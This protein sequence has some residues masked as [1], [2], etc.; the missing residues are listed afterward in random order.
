MRDWKEV[1]HF[2]TLIL[3]LLT[4]ARAQFTG[5][6]TTLR[7]L[8]HQSSNFSWERIRS[9]QP[10]SGQCS[11]LY[12]KRIPNTFQALIFKCFSGPCASWPPA[13]LAGAS[14][15]WCSC[16]L[17]TWLIMIVGAGA[18]QV[19]LISSCTWLRTRTISIVL[20]STLLNTIKLKS[21]ATYW[22]SRPCSQTTMTT[23]QS[24]I[25]RKPR[26]RSHLYRMH[27]PS[28]RRS[29]RDNCGI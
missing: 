2:G 14:Q 22:T 6:K 3:K 12:S 23:H 24:K 10:S 19:S 9:T 21:H 8:N 29:H 4:Q 25:K 28:M 16:R 20:I 5:H 11:N 26:K 27:S 7:K 15:L 1:P 13:V 17:L 18:Q